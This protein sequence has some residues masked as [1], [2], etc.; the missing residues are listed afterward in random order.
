MLAFGVKRADRRRVSR[1]SV[2]AL[3]L[4]A[5]VLPLAALFTVP[6]QAGAQTDDWS[7]PRTVFIPDTGQTIDGVFLD[8]WREGGGVSA[9]GNPITQELTENGHTVQYYEYARFEYVPEDPDGIVVHL[10]DIGKELKPVTVFRT[11]PDL[12]GSGK[13]DGSVSAL[14]HEARAWL[15]LDNAAAQADTDTRTYV[16]ETQHTVQSG[17]KEFWDSTGGVDYLGNPLTEDYE[18]NGIHYQVFE[19]GKLGWTEANGV[20]MIPVGTILAKQYH[21]DTTGT[22]T[23]DYPTYSEDLFTPPVTPTPEVSGEA[24]ELWIEVNLSDEYLIVWNG[25][26]DMGETYVSTGREGFDTP[27]GTFYINSKAESQTM[28]GVLGGEYYNVPDV[29]WVMYFTDLGHALHGTYWHDNFGVPMSH[30]CINLP[31]D[32]AAWLYGIADVGTRVEIH[33]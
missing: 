2:A 16:A 20:Y 26:I 24:G 32:F 12:K 14:A 13:N 9:Y 4:V 29:P 10:G 3:A 31:M 8:Q 25:T 33:Y 23:S 15:P 6:G 30:G 1:V 22:P 7:A 19:R 28:E 18:A 17:F 11:V 5:L 27:T 21:L